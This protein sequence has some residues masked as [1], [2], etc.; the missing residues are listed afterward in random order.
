MA[1]L[2]ETMS[3]AR[4]RSTSCARLR[5]VMSTMM[6]VACWKLPSSSR[7]AETELGTQT[8]VPSFRRRRLSFSKLWL[9]SAIVLK[10][11]LCLG[12]VSRNADTPRSH[13]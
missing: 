3:A 12:D 8:N 6:A 7:S 5:S 13:R 2:D 11:P 9:H 4:R 10:E 1:L